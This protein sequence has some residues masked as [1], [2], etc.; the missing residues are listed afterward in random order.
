MLILLKIKDLKISPTKEDW[1]DKVSAA[2]VKS[3]PVEF[4]YKEKHRVVNPYKLVNNEGVWYLFA[5]EKSD[6]KVLAFLK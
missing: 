5:E 1:F 4:T 3:N 6:L 2:I